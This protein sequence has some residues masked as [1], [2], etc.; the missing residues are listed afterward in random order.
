M[1]DRSEN[2][3][4]EMA[5]RLEGSELQWP[6]MAGVTIDGGNADAEYYVEL[7]TGD[8]G[9]PVALVVLGEG[10]H[11]FAED[12][13][14][15]ERENADEFLG[16]LEFSDAWEECNVEPWTRSSR[17]PA[18]S[19]GSTTSR[20]LAG[21]TSCRVT[22]ARPRRGTGVSMPPPTGRS[23]QRRRRSSTLTATTLTL[24][25]TPCSTR[26]Y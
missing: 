20:G 9:N 26:S 13:N 22:T 7:E 12:L 5:L 14:D 1:S 23:P 18:W 15:D 8:E 24:A 11:D 2:W 3:D 25:P 21:I 10:S 17:A 4:T 19:V 6:I 16:D